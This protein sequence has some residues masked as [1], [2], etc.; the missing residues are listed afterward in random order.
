MINEPIAAAAGPITVL[1]ITVATSVRATASK[2]TS[3][4]RRR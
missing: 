1:R 4:A 3:R 2:A